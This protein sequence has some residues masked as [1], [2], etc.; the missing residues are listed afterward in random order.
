MS[1]ALQTLAAGA[2]PLTIERGRPLVMGIVKVPARTLVGVYELLSCPF[3]LP[4]GYEPLLT[5][6]YPWEY[7]EAEPGEVYGF[8]DRYLSAEL[9]EL[10][11]DKAASAEESLTAEVLWRMEYAVGLRSD[12]PPEPKPAQRP[13]L[14]PDELAAEVA[15]RLERQFG[16]TQQE[17]DK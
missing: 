8:S 3:P 2:R 17:N 11:R 16:I 9:A 15:D 1:S 7:F 5:P 12:Q 10:N 4:A 6:E 13:R 14:S